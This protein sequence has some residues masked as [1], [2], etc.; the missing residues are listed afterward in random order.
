MPL[1]ALDL[2]SPRILRGSWAALAAIYN[3]RGWTDSSYATEKQW[4]YHD[5]GGNWCCLRFQAHD[6]LVLVGHDHEYSETYYA[7][8]AEY[9]GEEETNLLMDAP[10]WWDQDLDSQPFG[11]WIG[12]V[13][14]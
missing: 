2:P 1:I 4:C 8:A 6:R 14:G 5:G 9:F 10:D 13:Y 7:A 11:E 12:F 3:A